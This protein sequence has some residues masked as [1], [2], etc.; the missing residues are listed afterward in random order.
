ME[1]NIGLIV[2]LLSLIVSGVL[3][4]S[5]LQIRLSLAE[6]ILQVLNGRYLKRD[7]ADERF[8]AVTRLEKKVETLERE[9]QSLR[10][11]GC[12][13]RRAARACA[14]PRE[15]DED[16]PNREQDGWERG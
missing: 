16:E 4:Y 6:Q 11:H 10:R 2:S 1:Q 7:I 13:G 15:D 8:K 5:Y 3:A 9:L 14:P 12:D